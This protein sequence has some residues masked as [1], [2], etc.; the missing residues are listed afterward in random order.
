MISIEKGK[1]IERS[2]F[3][4]LPRGVFEVIFNDGVV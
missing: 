3:V 2:F 1:K 4:L